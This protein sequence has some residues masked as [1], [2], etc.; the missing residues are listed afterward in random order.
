MNHA[1]GSLKT[2][3]HRLIWKDVGRVLK[4]RKNY[5]CTGWAEVAGQYFAALT[6][7]EVYP[8]E[9]SFPKHSINELLDKLDKFTMS[10]P[11]HCTDC[12]WNWKEQMENTQIWTAGAFDG[13]CIDC[14][15][16]SNRK[17]E[18][19]DKDYWQR[20]GKGSG[21]WDQDCRIYHGE[22]TWYVSWCGRDEHRRK[23]VDEAGGRP[24]PWKRL[25]YS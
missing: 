3:L 13:L 8:L 15:D 18:A 6:D 7:T 25:R 17:H 10:Q 21:G 4:E 24:R 23:L 14:M 1:R 2:T 5:K 22:S 12:S 11:F 9:L 16:K 19:F 20:L